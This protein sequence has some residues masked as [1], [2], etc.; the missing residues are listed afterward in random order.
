MKESIELL[1]EEFEQVAHRAQTLT[2]PARASELQEEAIRDVDT[3][4]ELLEKQKA[5][6]QEQREEF[7]A[8]AILGME[9]S[10]ATVRSELTM[11]LRLKRDDPESAWNDLIN[12]QTSLRS[13][14]A[15]RRQLGIHTLTL[16]NLQRKFDFIERFIFPP[17]MFN[18][19]GG[20]V[21][22]RECS[23][24]G[25]DYEECDHIAGRAYMGRLCYCI[26]REFSS[27]DHVALVED[28][29]DKRCRIT[30]FSEGPKMRNKMT[31]RLEERK[32]D[33]ATD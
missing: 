11:W 7:D 9:L 13:A 22:W 20:T 16:E 18:S 29:A 3:F 33:P 25:H 32:A 27:M 28:P 21:A 30:H 14:I 19:I 31:W 12:A 17:Q 10:L 24:C 26:L 5:I 2:F 23:I 8:N 6:A 4:L 1:I 15:V